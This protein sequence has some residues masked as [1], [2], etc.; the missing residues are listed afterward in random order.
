MTSRAMTGVACASTTMTAS[1]PTMIPLLGSPSAVKAQA[2]AESRRNEIFFGLRS[3]CEAN[4]VI[5]I[6]GVAHRELCATHDILFC[7]K[8]ALLGGGTIARLVISHLRKRDLRDVDVV[9]ICG[10]S[11]KSPSAT[12]AKELSIPHVLGADGLI[13][14][15]PDVVLEAA[16]HDAVREHLVSLLSAQISVIVLS[17]GALADDRLREEAT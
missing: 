13:R 6:P 2:L 16:S 3:A 1:S 8:L 7:M 4:D 17:A 10:R 15:R 12:L 11:S 9:A 14:I 5:E